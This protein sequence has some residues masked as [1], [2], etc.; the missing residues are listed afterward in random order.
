[1]I[2]RYGV[3]TEVLKLRT[4][5]VNASQM[6]DSIDE[7]NERKGGPLFKAANDPRVTRIGHFLRA[8]SIDELPQLWD[9]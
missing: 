7:L 4:M 9:V 2:G 8:A 6:L 3:N 1:M 5:V